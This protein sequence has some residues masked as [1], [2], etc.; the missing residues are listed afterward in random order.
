MTTASNDLMDVIS[1]AYSLIYDSVADAVEQVEI[2]RK[3]KEVTPIQSRIRVT[4]NRPLT[5]SEREQFRRDLTSN[6]ADAFGV[7]N[8]LEVKF[9]DEDVVWIADRE[10]AD[11]RDLFAG[12][13]MYVAESYVNI[14]PKA[15]YTE[16][17][18]VKV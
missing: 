11:H 5:Y 17:P 3:Q 7:G 18:R 15:V 6:D 9:S 10:S 8:G 12:L 14:H 4:F 2:D 13:A 16:I 1:K